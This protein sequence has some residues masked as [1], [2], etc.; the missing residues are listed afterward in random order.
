[1]RETAHVETTRVRT[2]NW[3]QRSESRQTRGRRRRAS[4]RSDDSCDVVLVNSKRAS[5]HARSD[6][7]ACADAR[8]D[9][10]RARTLVPDRSL[11]LTL[12]SCENH[13]H[14]IPVS[15]PA[16]RPPKNPNA[17]SGQSRKS[18]GPLAIGFYETTKVLS[19]LAALQT[20]TQFVA[21]YTHDSRCLPRN[22]TL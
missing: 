13:T 12:E 14:F 11:A 5:E 19:P 20:S 9:Q 22:A 18:L 2:P 1:M 10:S 16:Y 4:S 21:L 17:R 3:D 6:R 15:A 8:S 7:I